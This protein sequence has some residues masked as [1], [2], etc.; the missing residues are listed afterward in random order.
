[1]VEIEINHR[2]NKACSYCP[3]SVTE[4]SEKGEMEP[5]LFE[6]IMLD[7]QAINYQGSI[8]YEF[9]NEPMLAKNIYWFVE[10]TRKY[11]PASRIDFY[12]NGTLLSLDAFRKLTDLGVN[13]YIVTKHEGITDY[14]FDKTYGE[15]TAEEK[16]LVLY[17]TY[18]DL[19]M[20]NRGGL[21]EAGP[22]GPANLVPCF[23]PEFLIAI[24]VKG[25][26]LPCFEDYHQIN[27]MGNVGEM[28][29][30]EI[31]NN[32]LF[33]TFRNDLRLGL[34]HKQNPCLKCNR[35]QV[36]LK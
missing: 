32:S 10:T 13:R 26:V 5:A 31:L 20:T 22:V 16:K 7:L 4:R 3:N 19:K 28:P 15:I 23:I 11:L 6:K 36:C 33:N 21:V 30:N 17:Q 8:S 25:H 14:I 2:C 18:Q 34:R 1:M 9:Y 24:T 35:T 27:N 12:T 29:L